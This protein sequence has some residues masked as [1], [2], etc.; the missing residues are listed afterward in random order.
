MEN[1]VC[2]LMATYNGEKYVQEMLESLQN[3]SYKNFVCYIHDDGSTDSTCEIL[4]HFCER[5]R[6]F[7]RLNSQARGGQKT[8][9]SIY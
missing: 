3:Q 9:F 6:N 2:I 8:I 5:N 4:D 7:I 1:K